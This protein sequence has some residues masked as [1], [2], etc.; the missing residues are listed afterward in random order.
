MFVYRDYKWHELPKLVHRT[1]KTLSIVMILIGFAASF[2]YIM[3]LMQ[4]PQQI[5][6]TVHQHLQTT[7]MW[8]C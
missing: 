3:T 1:V 4:I 2:G 5:T 7:S 8:C 6:G